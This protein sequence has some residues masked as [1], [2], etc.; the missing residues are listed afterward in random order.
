M[1]FFLSPEGQKVALESGDSDGYFYLLVEEVSP[2]PLVSPIEQIPYQKVD[3][4]VWGPREAEINT[5]LANTVA[6]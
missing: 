1:E 6:R 3:P 2:H 5:W 4:N